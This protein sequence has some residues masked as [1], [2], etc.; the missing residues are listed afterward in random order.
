MEETVP[1]EADEQRLSRIV[2]I[3]RHLDR[4]A[5]ESRLLAAGA[6]D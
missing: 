3:G 2:I 5:L 4:A 6:G 1:W